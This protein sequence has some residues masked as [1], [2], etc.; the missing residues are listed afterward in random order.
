MKLVV[1]PDSDRVEQWLIDAASTGSGDFIDLRQVCTVGQLVERC[2]PAR[3]S[4]L[5]PAEPLLVRMVL[6]SHAS[7]A[8][9]AFG[10][11]AR[12]P[13]F[14]G[15]VH[16]VLSHLR[17]QNVTPRQLTLAAEGVDERL[18]ARTHALVALWNALDSTL[19]QRGLV[20]RAELVRLAARRLREEGLPPRLRGFREVEVRHVHDLFPA[21]LELLE[22]F[23]TACH[24]ADVGLQLWWPSTGQQEADL[25]VLDAVRAVE[26][27][28]QT[29]SAEAF[30]DLSNASLSWVTPA[31]FSDSPT[32]RAA[33]QLTAFSAPTLRD[34]ARQ[35]ASRVKTLV[36]AGVP[37]ERICVAFRDLAEDTEALV[38]ALADLDVPARA[39]LGVPL[40]ASAPGRLALSLFELVDDAFPA[41][42]LAVLLE[43][44]IVSVLPAEAADPRRTFLEAG[45]RD[46]LV[47]ATAKAGAFEVRL[48]SLERRASDRTPVSILRATVKDLLRL[49]RQIPDEARATELLEAWWDALTRLGVFARLSSRPDP[50]PPRQPLLTRELDRA[51]A[52]DQAAGEALLGLLASLKESLRASGLGERRMTRRDFARHVRRAAQDLNLNARGPRTGAVWLLDARELAGR[53]FD[54]VFLGGLVDGRMPGRAAPLP[55]LTEDDRAALN[56]SGKASLFRLSVGDSGLRLPLKLAEDRLLLHFALCAGERV[57]LSRSR[58]DASGRELLGSPFRD[59]LARA[60]SGLEEVAVARGPVAPLDSVQSEAELRTRV[61]LELACPPSTRQT[62]QDPRVPGLEALLQAEPWLVEARQVSAMEVER[63]RFFSDPTRASGRFTGQLDEAVMGPLLAQLSF[64]STRPV[65][66]AQFNVWATCAFQGLSRFL[67][68][69]DALEAAGEEADARVRGTFWHDVLRALVPVLDRQGLLG[70]NDAP[71][72]QVHAAID[73]AIAS[74]AKDLEAT[75]PI[76]HP[77]LW[78]LVR[79]RTATVMRR[80]VASEAIA[81]FPHAHVLEVEAEFGTARATVAELR[82]VKLPG[83]RPGERDVFIRGQIDRVDQ[84]DG[85]AGI[86][87]YKTSLRP[88]SELASAVLTSDFQLP[89][90]LLAVATWLPDAQLQALWLDMRRR[91]LRRAEEVLKGQSLR[92][93]VAIDAEARDRLEAEGKPNL[94]NRVHQVL[95][96]LR[97]GDFGARPLDCTFCKMRAVCRISSKR[98]G[99]G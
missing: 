9:R 49:L 88:R 41:D 37:P 65:S 87:D 26:A 38:E 21:R 55:L 95:G 72:A 43:S 6:A 60:V 74:S 76:G 19:E 56:A 75:S 85:L 90:Y 91:E 42:D 31:A 99:G 5:S 18:A 66:A 83:V 45:V 48:E 57:V 98:M 1:V 4:G 71:L 44:R 68:G 20:D 94:A 7:L 64:D 52:R 36:S 12:T 35:I 50:L 61:A 14:A 11:V 80:L 73:E 63:L 30:A 15:H 62:A 51:L 86:I 67:L 96:A 46:D 16:E 10:P 22:A 82:H 81:P 58:L 78:E 54:V 33:E 8:E 39:R 79:L 47:G 92:S 32:P 3:W 2:E 17:A 40:L 59:A 69:L 23:A 89:F 84:A 25:F 70:R 34:E 24:A 29:L 27:R 97:S 53:T 93:L 13:D 28:W 77:A